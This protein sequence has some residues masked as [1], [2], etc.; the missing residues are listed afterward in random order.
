MS[1]NKE[2]K[3]SLLLHHFVASLP[4]T[5]TRQL[6]ASGEVKTLEL[7]VTCARFFVDSQPEAAIKETTNE[8]QRYVS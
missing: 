2:S 6:R 7:A 8:H 5:I 1:L 3:D 4:E